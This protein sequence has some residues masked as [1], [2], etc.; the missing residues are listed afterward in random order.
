MAGGDCDA[1]GNRRR[2]AAGLIMANSLQIGA[3]TAM[4]LRNIPERW[5]SSLVAVIGVT[6]VSRSTAVL[7]IAEGFR[8]AL[9]LS[10][11]E[12]VAIVLR[13]GSTDEL[14]SG[15]GQ[16]SVPVI[17]DAAG[18]KRDA[19]GVRQISPELFVLVDAKMR[20]KSGAANA[21]MRGVGAV[22]PQLRKNFR[23]LEGRM[24]REGTNEVVVGN[25][26]AE[27]YEGSGR[28]TS[29][30]LGFDQLDRGWSL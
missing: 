28:W 27:Q 7:S 24:F 8:A 19:R 14:T 29:R 5:A 30:A 2:S 9:E 3:V 22:A 11:S 16:D 13:Q 21:P 15:F 26:V 12:D 10:G 20:G 25:G 23:L 17:G 1:S 6:G 18:V 4:N